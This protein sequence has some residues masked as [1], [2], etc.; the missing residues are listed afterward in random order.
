MRRV[1]AL[2]RL[3]VLSVLLAGLVAPPVRAESWAQFLVRPLLQALGLDESAA[4]LETLGT[5]RAVLTGVRLGPALTA[6]RVEVTF[7]PLQLVRG[8]V[9]AVR[10]FGAEGAIDFNADGNPVI[11]GLRLPNPQHEANR[12]TGANPQARPAGRAHRPGLARP[13]GRLPAV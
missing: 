11:P 1:A 13:T 6:R 4:T 10:I 5:D 8:R 2:T 7:D 9:D 3:L 12:Q